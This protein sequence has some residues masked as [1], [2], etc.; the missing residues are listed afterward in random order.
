MDD[1][2]HGFQPEPRLALVESNRGQILLPRPRT[3]RSLDHREACRSLAA[4]WWRAAVAAYPAGG[5]G[6]ARELG[7]DRPTVHRYGTREKLLPFGDVL[8]A[9]PEVAARVLRLGLERV[10]QA[11]LSCEGSL[12]GEAL[13]VCAEGVALAARLEACRP[14]TLSAGAREDLAAWAERLALRLWRIA[15][16]L[17]ESQSRNRDIDP[18][19]GERP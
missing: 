8:A 7:A 4:S 6:V 16:R 9:P 17:R 12:M 11:P 15:R 5:A 2:D 14:E 19:T 13:R 10:E 18:T 1:H 3:L